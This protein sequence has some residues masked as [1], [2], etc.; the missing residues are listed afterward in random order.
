[1]KTSLD[2]RHRL[3]ASALFDLPIGEEDRQPSQSIGAWTRAFS[4]IEIA[5]IFT[6]GTGTPVN[7]ITVATTTSRAR[8]PSRRARSACRG[9]RSGCRH[10]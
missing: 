10:R 5:P 8:F 7:G 1:L 4:H 9:M 3:V 6:V 2:Q